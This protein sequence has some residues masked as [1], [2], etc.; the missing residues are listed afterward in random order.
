MGTG[1]QQKMS[2]YIVKN[3]PALINTQFQKLCFQN[4]HIVDCC[5]INDCIIKRTVNECKKLIEG[6]PYEKVVFGEYCL[7][8]EIH[9]MFEI[10][11]VEE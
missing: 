9:D 3:C 2:K 10:Q 4:R 5:Q 7:A 1:G 6:N 11:E 8:K